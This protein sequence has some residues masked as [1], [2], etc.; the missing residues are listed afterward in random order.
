MKSILDKRIKAKHKKINALKMLVKSDEEKKLNESKR[1]PEIDGIIL[2]IKKVTKR[3]EN[4][5]LDKNPSIF[6][7]ISFIFYNP[8]VRKK[9]N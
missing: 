1:C 5:I 2:K 7:I 8:M 4:L 9:K 6:L 3:V